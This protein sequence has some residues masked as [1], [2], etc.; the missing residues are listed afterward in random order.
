MKLNC[1]AAVACVQLAQEYTVGRRWA[2][3]A[4]VQLG[5]SIETKWSGRTTRIQLGQV[6][7]R[8]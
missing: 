1:R 3:S 7:A 8:A 4:S 2:G 5:H 6:P